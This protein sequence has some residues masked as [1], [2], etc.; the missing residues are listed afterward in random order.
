M[1]NISPDFATFISGSLFY[2][3]LANIRN[4]LRFWIPL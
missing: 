4:N 2:F 3:L 1:E